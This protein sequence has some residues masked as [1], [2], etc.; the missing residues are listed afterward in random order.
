MAGNC[1]QDGVQVTL[2]K[3]LHVP[4]MDFNLLFSNVLLQKDSKSV[5]TYHRD[6]YLPCWYD[7]GERF[8]ILKS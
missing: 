8:P 6:E 4:G 3:A 7:R 1:L 2:E 5:C